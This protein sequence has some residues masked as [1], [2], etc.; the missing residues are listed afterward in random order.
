MG[1]EFIAAMSDGSSGYY[2]FEHEVIRNAVGNVETVRAQMADALELMGYRV[3]NENPLQA[4]RSAKN[5]A[6]SGCSA[7]ILDYQTSLDVGFKST[8]TNST[9][10]TFAYTVKGVYSGYLSKGDR[11]TLT[12]EAEAIVA[13]AMART[14]ATH[15]SACGNDTAGSSR[16]C[17]R[18]GSPLN[19]KAP[20]ELELLRLTAKANASSKN[21]GTGLLFMLLA[22]LILSPLLFVGDPEK[23][24]RLLRI[25]PVISGSFGVTGLM[26]ILFGVRRLRKAIINPIKQEALPQSQRQNVIE[27]A[28]PDTNELPPASIQHPITEATT[29]LLPHEIKRAS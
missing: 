26:M 6:Q 15:C 14:A 8:G 9:R 28:A 10:L 3:L 2:T 16:F 21:I 17:R 18:C 20:A 12:R 19:A 27:I 5:S 11:K 4:R 25:L 24:A 23:F 7:D 1:A 29:D 22:V 13:T